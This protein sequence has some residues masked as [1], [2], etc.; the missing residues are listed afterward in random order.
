MEDGTI[1]KLFQEFDNNKWINSNKNTSETL[2]QMMGT[3]KDEYDI[4]RTLRKVMEENNEYI[5][6][7]KPWFNTNQLTLVSSN[8][9]IYHFIKWYEIIMKIFVVVIDEKEYDA[10][11]K[12]LGQFLHHMTNKFEKNYNNI[13]NVEL[14]NAFVHMNYYWKLDMLCYGVDKNVKRLTL[15]QMFNEMRCVDQV[16]TEI[17]ENSQSRGFFS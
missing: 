2:Q 9:L 1:S 17:M 7:N 3:I 10:K 15:D 6:A 13:I 16:L 4:I 8:F 12:T 5:K 14:R 11:K